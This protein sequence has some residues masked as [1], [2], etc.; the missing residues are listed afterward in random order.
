MLDTQVQQ[1]I[2]AKAAPE[3]EQQ[4]APVTS[5]AQNRRL[6]GGI[7]LLLQMQIDV[8]QLIQLQGPGTLLNGRMGRPDAAKD[9]PHDR[10]LGGVGEPLI[11]IPASQGGQAL[12]ESVDA[13]GLGVRGQVARDAVGGGR[14]E[15]SPF[16]LEVADCGF[17]AAARV[18]ACRRFQVGADF[19]HFRHIHRPSYWPHQIA[20]HAS[21]SEDRNR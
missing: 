17:V 4:K 10:G 5:V 12:P 21:N 15:S 7:Y 8:L 1:F 2:A 6:A 9:L 14:Q 16:N 13:Q 19:V 11:N 3:S 18:D 20:F